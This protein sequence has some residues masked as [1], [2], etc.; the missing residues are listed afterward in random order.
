VLDTF[1]LELPLRSLFDE[2]ST[3]A[4]TALVITQNLAEMAGHEEMDRM[5]AELEGLS[6]EEVR[7]RFNDE[8]QKCDD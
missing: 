2:A 4:D 8:R 3:I 5:L 1:Q 6:E 7:S